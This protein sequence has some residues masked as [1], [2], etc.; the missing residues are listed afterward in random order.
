MVTFSLNAKSS[1]YSFLNDVLTL[2]RDLSSKG[3]AFDYI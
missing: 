2:L 3:D 1:L